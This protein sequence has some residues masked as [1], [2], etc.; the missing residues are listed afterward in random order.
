MMDSQPLLFH[1]MLKQEFS[2][3]TLALKDTQAENV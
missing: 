2:W 1:V 3:F